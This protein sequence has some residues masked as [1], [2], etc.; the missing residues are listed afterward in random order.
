MSLKDD[1][2]K[3]TVGSKSEYKTIQIDF[4]G[5]V[6]V[7]KQPSLRQRKDII[8]KSVGE[9]REIDGVSMQVWSVIYLTHDSEGNRVFDE[10]D[11]DSLM[12]KPAGSFVDTFAESAMKLLGNMEEDEAEQS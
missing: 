3:L 10:T 5:S 12:E 6:V 9:D 11:Y 2:R 7:F 8:T 4:K 1:L